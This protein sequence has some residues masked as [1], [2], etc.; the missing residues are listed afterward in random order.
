MFDDLRTTTLSLPSNSESQ[1]TLSPPTMI[2]RM[3]M[4]VGGMVRAIRVMDRV[5]EAFLRSVDSPLLI[6]LG[7]ELIG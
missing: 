5:A 6:C 7:I 3:G 2:G 1:T 4:V